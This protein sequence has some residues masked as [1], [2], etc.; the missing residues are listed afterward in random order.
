MPNKLFQKIR[1]VRKLTNE[2]Y[3]ARIT[4]ILKPD[5]DNPKPKILQHYTSI[6]LMDRNEKSLTKS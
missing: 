6:S 1:R 4:L 2:F 5:K 3:E